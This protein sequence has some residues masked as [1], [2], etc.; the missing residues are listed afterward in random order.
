MAI[1][2]L[3]VY[4]TP[5]PGGSKRAFFRG[6]KAIVVPDNKHTATWREA[7]KS[8]AL[9]QAHKKFPP[10]TPLAV[11]MVFMFRR[12]QSHYRSG[13][14]ASKLKPNA[15]SYHI[16]TPDCTKL[17]RS[18][19]DALTGI[20]WDDDSRVVQQDNTKIYCDKSSDEGAI[21]MITRA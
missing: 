20:L 11:T 4:D 1:I 8:A 12:P 5:R 9:K 15:P 7:V 16:S 2:M 3:R 17:V 6:S 18:T 14:N 19:E 10:K 21:V 13:K